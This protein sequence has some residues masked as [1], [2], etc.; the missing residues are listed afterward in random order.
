M[1]NVEFKSL[2]I[3][4]KPLIG[5]FLK[6][7]NPI[8]V[9]IM[10]R[11]GFDFL[12]IDAEHAPF[13]RGSIDT[14]ILAGRAVNCPVV[15][16]VPTS[17]S[18]WILNVLDAGAAGVIVPHVKSVEQAVALAKSVN[19]E[20]DGRGFAGTTRA[21]DYAGKSLVEHLD[22]ARDAFALICMIEDPPG[23]TNHAAI[24]SVEGVDALFV[25]RADLAVSHG[26]N[27]FFHPQVSE[28]AS[29]I[30]SAKSVATGLYC[31]ISE[32][33]S[34]HHD[35]GASFFVVGSDHA[36]L[37]EGAKESIGFF[38]KKFTK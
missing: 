15:V 7:P 1:N 35:S 11:A 3:N 2:L 6:T 31:A 17:T 25:G 4:R 8:S 9:E 21:A 13:D 10:A 24:A 33:L 14:M 12:V 19:Y 23:V 30:L 5:S 32:N 26:F 20:P 38:N 29:Q 18:D 16:R 36:F 34:E 37:L 28:I 22:T 27:D